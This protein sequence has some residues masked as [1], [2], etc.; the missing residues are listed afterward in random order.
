MC[1]KRDVSASAR[2]ISAKFLTVSKLV[3]LEYYAYAALHVE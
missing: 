2:T 1:C 3:G